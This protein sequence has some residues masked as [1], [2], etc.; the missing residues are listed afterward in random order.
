ALSA[1]MGRTVARTVANLPLAIQAL[2]QAPL[3]RQYADAFRASLTFRVVPLAPAAQPET[4][5]AAGR[6]RAALIIP[7]HFA[8]ELRR[9]R[10]VQTQLLVDATD[11]H[12]AKLIRG[13]AGQVTS[14]FVRQLG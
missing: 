2:D 7:A 8:R 13:S 3:S 5:L 11:G 12:T 10:P 1:R 6:A 14:A 9:H 4:M